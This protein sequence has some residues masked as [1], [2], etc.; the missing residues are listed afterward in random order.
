[1]MLHLS[2]PAARAARGESNVTN[3]I[4]KVNFDDDNEGNTDS[5]LRLLSSLE[6]ITVA[7]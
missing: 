6:K 4:P 3:I 5:C 7:F 1:M 2:E